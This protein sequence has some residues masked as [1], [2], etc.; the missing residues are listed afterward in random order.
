M[1]TSNSSTNHNDLKKLWKNS[2]Y[3]IHNKYKLTSEDMENILLKESS[4]FM[5]KFR[6]NIYFDIVLKSVMI[7]GLTAMWLIYPSNLLVAGVA[8]FLIILNLILIAKLSGLLKTSQLKNDFTKST[9]E[10]LKTTIGLYTGQVSVIP[11]SWSFSTGTFY[12]LGSFLYYHFKYGVIN[13]FQ[14]I[15]DIVI[16]CGFMV[17]GILISYLSHLYATNGQFKRLTR[18]A[19]DMNDESE[20]HASSIRYKRARLNL[21]LMGS[22]ISFIGLSLLIILIFILRS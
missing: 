17:I 22:I 5:K 12:V 10:T 11:L 1:K 15:Q 9:A 7:C 8:L 6:A 21:L 3:L 14:D 2:G 20:F 13:P 16:L 19:D 18:L 4:G